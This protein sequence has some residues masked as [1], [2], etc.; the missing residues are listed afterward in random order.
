[1]Y[2][3]I[4]AKELIMSKIIRRNHYQTGNCN[5]CKYLH[6]YY[7]MLGKNNILTTLQKRFKMLGYSWALTYRTR[8]DE[9]TFIKIEKGK[10]PKIIYLNGIQ[11]EDKDL[12]TKH[13]IPGFITPDRFEK[14]LTLT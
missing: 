13:I 1:M 9:T 4:C 5:D 11:Y 12:R 7:V 3:F 2:C 10:S 14:I 8:S 6:L